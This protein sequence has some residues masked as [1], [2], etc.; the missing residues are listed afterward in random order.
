MRINWVVAS[1]Y[2]LDPTVDIEKIKSI[3][4]VWG[5]WNTWRSCGTDNVIC[6]DFSKSKD[7]IS[8]AFQSV[9]NFY[10]PAK[11]YQ[12]LGRPVGLKLYDG[13]F[14]QE[15]NNLD[16]IVAM[17]LCSQQSDLILLLGFDLSLS[18]QIQDPYEIHR[19]KNYHGLIRSLIVNH[20]GVQWVC[21]DHTTDLAKPYTEIEN[22]SKDTL[23]KV[24]ETL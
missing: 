12:D 15:V 20:P 23:Q 4:S 24:F 21:V 1:G 7:L 13:E 10:V 11:H 3:G 19:Y 16:D 9:C 22:L 6:S 2:Q 14:N 8:R 5:S 17:H 18:G